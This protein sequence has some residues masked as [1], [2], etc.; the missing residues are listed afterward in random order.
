VTDPQ[1]NMD[2]LLQAVIRLTERP[3]QYVRMPRLVDEASRR[4]TKYT[5]GDVVFLAE[6]LIERG[7]LAPY[8]YEGNR[9]SGLSAAYRYE[10]LIVLSPDGHRIAVVDYDGIPL[11][12]PGHLAENLRPG[13]KIEVIPW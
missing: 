1:P 5:I 7:L 13:I 3:G 6:R 12:D 9:W 2:E 4:G 8:V 10:G 11:Q